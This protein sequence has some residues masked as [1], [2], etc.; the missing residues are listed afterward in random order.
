[1]SG[2]C[3][4]EVAGA[5]RSIYIGIHTVTGDHPLRD[6]LTIAEARTFYDRFEAR[7]DSQSFYEDAAVDDLLAHSAFDSARHVFELGCGTGRV[8]ERI[9]DATSATYAGVDVSDT[10]I[11]LSSSRL[12]RFGER[13]RVRRTDGGDPFDGMS[14]RPDR[15]VTTYV[16]D[17]LPAGAI[18]AFVDACARALPRDGRLCMASLTFGNTLVSRVVTAGWRGL[19]RISPRVV[20]GCRPVRLLPF[21][22]TATWDVVHHRVITSF[23]VPS[24]VVVASKIGPT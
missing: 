8:A 13:A 22:A 7:Q 16:V 21:L 15:V 14:E 3:K 24:E 2:H 11:R 23:G 19:F 20:G 6:A 1:M 9:L 18:A 17:L 4:H 5:A 10:M 12:A